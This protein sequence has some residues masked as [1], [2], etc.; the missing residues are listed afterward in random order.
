MLSHR[1]AHI[2]FLLNNRLSFFFC[3]FFAFPIF[4]EKSWSF[5]AAA[6]SNGRFF[7]IWTFCYFWKGGRSSWP[8]K[9]WTE[10]RRRM[11]ERKSHKK[12]SFIV[13]EA[14]KK[15]CCFRFLTNYSIFSSLNKQQK[16]ALGER[17]QWII[18]MKKKIFFIES[19]NLGYAYMSLCKCINIRAHE[20][21]KIIYL[22][23]SE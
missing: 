2:Y 10:K 12:F 13:I 22:S 16:L 17:L 18:K 3:L 6:N 20:Y 1:I 15:C 23:K 19:C 8:F 21:S 5:L 7:P 4:N 11:Y 9:M 14:Y